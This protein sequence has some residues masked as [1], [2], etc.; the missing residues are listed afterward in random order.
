MQKPVKILLGGVEYEIKPLAL[1]ESRAWR[2][3]LNGPLAEVTAALKGAGEIQ[4]TNGADI[5]ALLETLSSRVVLAPDLIFELLLAYAP[6]LAEDRSRIE[7]TAT[8]DETMVG[9]VAVLALAFPFGKLM[10]ALR[11]SG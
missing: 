4:V 9:F 7:E 10:G 5:A 11:G 1:R 3:Q 8:D 2:Q 6:N